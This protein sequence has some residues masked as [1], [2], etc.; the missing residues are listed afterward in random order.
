MEGRAVTPAEVLAATQ[1]AGAVLTARGGQLV[2]EA[3]AP[4]PDELV[5]AIRGHKDELLTMLMPTP[6][7]LLEGAAGEYDRLGEQIDALADLAKAAR[8]RGDIAE[9][10]RLGAEVRALVV[11]PYLRAR[12]RYVAVL[13]TGTEGEL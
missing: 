3:D 11:G 8:A 5:A 2:V 4:L 10:E 13:S 12:E 6:A 7:D 1:E 9:G